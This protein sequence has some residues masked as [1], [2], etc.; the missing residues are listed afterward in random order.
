[1]I[2]VH[3]GRGPPR[4]FGSASSSAYGILSLFQLSGSIFLAVQ[5]SEFGRDLRSGGSGLRGWSAT[6]LTKVVAVPDFI[7]S[8]GR[9]KWASANLI[10]DELCH[11]YLASSHSTFTSSCNP[12]IRWPNGL[13]LSIS[14]L[15]CQTPTLFL[16][17]SDKDFPRRGVLSYQIFIVSAPSIAS[18]T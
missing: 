14:T 5:W 6:E 8:E 9:R 17:R 12:S 13:A 4:R 2:C 7:G 16:S 18:R 3:L 15:I 11:L 1:M 10:V